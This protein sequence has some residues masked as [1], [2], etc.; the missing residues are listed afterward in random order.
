MKLTESKWGREEAG[1]EERWDEL[2]RGR[3][4]ARTSRGQE[5]VMEGEMIKVHHIQ[6]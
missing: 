4:S 5:R 1:K 2:G 3:G 6:K